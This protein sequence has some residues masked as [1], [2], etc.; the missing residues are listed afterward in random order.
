TDKKFPGNPTR[1]YR[2]KSSLRIVGEVLD[3]KG[4]APEVLRNMLDNL[5]ELKRQGI[6]AIND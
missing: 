6:E 3:W 1:S 2:T 4:H 5:E